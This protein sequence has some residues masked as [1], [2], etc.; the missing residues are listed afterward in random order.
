MLPL[1]TI[2]SVPLPLS[3]RNK[4]KLE[5]KLLDVISPKGTY[6]LKNKTQGIT[7]INPINS[8]PRRTNSKK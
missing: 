7:P 6:S 2:P 4:L 1:E 3:N 8:L 5:N